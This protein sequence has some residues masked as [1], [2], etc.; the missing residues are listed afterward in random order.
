MEGYSVPDL[1]FYG[2]FADRDH[3]GSEFHSDGDL[4]LL[5]EAVVDELQEEAGLSDASNHIEFIPVSPIMMNLNMYEKDIL[6]DSR[7]KL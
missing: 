6:S 1:E 7:Y 4:V 5:P 2:L 3:L